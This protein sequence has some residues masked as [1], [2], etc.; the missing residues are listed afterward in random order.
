MKEMS[1]RIPNIDLSFYI[2]IP[3]LEN[4]HKALGIAIPKPSVSE[5]M[6]HGEV[7]EEVE[8]EEGD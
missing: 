1:E 2:D 7:E 5:D 3:T 8:S 6:H 4:V